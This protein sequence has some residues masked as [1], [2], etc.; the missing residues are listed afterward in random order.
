VTFVHVAVVAA[1]AGLVAVAARWPEIARLALVVLFAAAGALNL[2]I[3]MTSPAEVLDYAR[4]APIDGVRDFLLGFF[5]RHTTPIVASI[6]AGQ[7]AIAWLLA[8]RRPASSFGVVAAIA[9]FLA[10]TPLGAGSAFPAPLLFA[11]AALVVGR[12]CGPR[13]SLAE[14]TS[15]WRA[16]RRGRRGRSASAST[17]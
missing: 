10:I 1:A 4:L 15:S 16:W 17:A 14:L 7:I 13:S 8:S 6:A 5:A 2:R 12:R 9:F 3:G 11:L